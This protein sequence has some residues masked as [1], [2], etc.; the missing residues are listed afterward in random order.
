MRFTRLVRRA[1]MRLGMNAQAQGTKPARSRLSG[2]T[3][4]RR[5]HRPITGCHCGSVPEAGDRSMRPVTTP[6]SRLEPAWFLEPW[7]LA[8]GTLS[9]LPH[10]PSDHGYSWKV[11]DGARSGREERQAMLD[12]GR[13]FCFLFTDLA[14][15]TSNHIYQQIGYRPVCDVDSYAFSEP[16]QE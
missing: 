10:G 12:A 6:C 15:P 9:V 3:L 14:N 1:E 8:H 16:E 5:P 13:T 2:A 4:V 11:P 7:P